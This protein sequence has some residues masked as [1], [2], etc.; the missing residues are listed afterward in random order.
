MATALSP[1]A[2]RIYSTFYT[3]KV[4]ASDLSG[5]K[6]SEFRTHDC[7]LAEK[8][9]ALT[10]TI[11]LPGC[12]NI[13]LLGRLVEPLP[14]EGKDSLLSGIAIR[15]TCLFLWVLSTPFAVISFALA[16]IVRCI[17][18]GFRPAISFI[19]NSENAPPKSKEELQLTETKPL[20]IRT[21]NLGF[22][23]TALSTAGDLR[24]PAKRAQ[25]LVTSIVNDPQMPDIIFFQ[26][27]FHEDATRILCE[28]IK[29]KYPF[30]IH[31]VAPQISCFNS[32][33]MIAS[34][35][36]IEDIY[37]QRLKNMLGPELLSPR[38]ILR[39]QVQS[40]TGPLLMYSVHTQALIGEER[41]NS[42]FLQ[43][44]EIKEL[45]EADAQE[46]PQVLQVLVGDFNTSRVTVWG[47]DNLKPEGQAEAKVINFLE[48]N[49]QDLYL[50]DH[51][52]V[53]GKRTHGKPIFLKT[54]NTRL[55]EDLEEPCGSWYWGPFADPGFLL[56]YKM[57]LDRKLNPDVVI[58]KQEN[59]WGTKQWHAQQATTAARLD[60][61]L[62]PK[63]SKQLDGKVEIR[64]GFVPKEAQSGLSDHLAVDA[65]IYRRT[66]KTAFGDFAFQYPQDVRL[67]QS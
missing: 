32:G 51:D 64:R 43:L 46:N 20:H 21:H 57:S 49:F 30:I 9:H 38:G 40:P 66:I 56:G 36:P 18:H 53:T 26:E 6:T 15:V 47:E 42:R 45:M 59:L 41:A 19:D 33:G 4:E 52:P 3:A 16:F 55:G 10:E 22:V 58:P 13:Q 25:E 24:D 31:S 34:K 37:F 54:D 17:E 29:E 1:Y 35:Y 48:E 60:Y 14:G 2:Y 8:L 11:A 44:Q 65:F 62:L 50:K 12:W 63:E 67:I 39:I 7:Y 61:I 28:G 27:A 23:T 5:L